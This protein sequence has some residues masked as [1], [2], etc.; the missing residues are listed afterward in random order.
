MKRILALGVMLALV[1]SLSPAEADELHWKKEWPKFRGSE[2]VVTLV[3]TAGIL[4]LLFIRLPPTW[5]GGVLFDD[6]VRDHWKADT[7][8]E[9]DRAQFWSTIGYYTAMVYPVVID[10][11]VTHARGSRT[12]ATQTTLINLEALAITGFVFRVT[13]FTVRRAR[14]FVNDC[15]EANGGN[16][17]LCKEQGLSAT[18]SFIGGHVALAAAG[19]AL[20][21]THHAN[22]PIYGG[23]FADALPCVAQI[24]I[25]A[26]V[27]YG[28]LVTDNH[29][30]TDTIAGIVVG[31]LVGWLVP[32][33]LH[34]GFDGKGVGSAR[35]VAVVPMGSSSML[36][37]GAIAVL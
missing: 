9:K 29:Y 26:G 17:E 23:G 32:S 1:A 25:V 13:E 21:C 20:T 12:V 22:L 11:F 5:G 35:K 33:A 18:N 14:P 27:G 3:S 36:G 4:S 10:G 16:F 6:T 8:S 37:L 30:A 28:R 31:G 7:E 24:G 34:Y 19:A 15:A 2:G